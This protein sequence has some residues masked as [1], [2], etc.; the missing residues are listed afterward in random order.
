MIC[1][2]GPK[3]LFVIF[4]P[5]CPYFRTNKEH[6]PKTKKY[7]F[8][9]TIIEG[10]L[11]QTFIIC[12]LSTNWTRVLN[13]SCSCQISQIILIHLISFLRR[14]FVK[15]ARPSLPVPERNRFVPNQV[16]EFASFWL[17]RCDAFV[18]YGIGFARKARTR[19]RI[20]FSAKGC[21]EVSPFCL[22]PRN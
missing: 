13:L 6:R 18:G 9:W 17:R 14:S 3:S 2:L 21:P 1:L 16:T 19:S 5:I 15:A 22:A 12:I 7:K 4:Y 8:D 10:I 11:R 20:R